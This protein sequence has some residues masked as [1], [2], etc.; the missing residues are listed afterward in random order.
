[1]ISR[2]LAGLLFASLI[3]ILPIDPCA[4]GVRTWDAG[5]DGVFW[6]HNC[7]WSGP[8]D[9]GVCFG[10]QPFD[11]DDAIIPFGN[12]VVRF[13]EG[14]ASVS[15][16]PG[17]RIDIDSALNAHNGVVNQAVI[18]IG[19]A[20]AQLNIGG[21]NP[22]NTLLQGGGEVI[23]ADSS[24]NPARVQ[25]AQFVSSVVTH[26]AG[27]TIR[28]EGWVVGKWINNG[29][30]R[31]EETSGDTSA[32]LS[33]FGT[34]TN[35]GVIRSS[36]TGAVHLDGALTMGAS[37]QFIADQTSIV[38]AGGSITGGTLQAINGAKFVHPSAVMTLS[39]VT[40]NG[41]LDVIVNNGGVTGAGTGI[42][43]NGTMTLDNQNIANGQ[44]HMEAGGTLNGS[45][46]V[47][48]NR[49]NDSTFISGNFTHG[50]N[51]TIRGSGRI[52]ATMV[53]N[54]SIFAEPRNGNLLRVPFSTISNN[55]L[56]QANGASTLRIEQNSII[57]Q[58]ASG[59][60]RALNGGTVELLFNPSIIGGRLQTE[61]TGLFVIP[62]GHRGYL[63]DVTNEGNFHADSGSNLRIEGTSLTNHGVI[64]INPAG[65]VGGTSLEF[66]SNVTIQ[67]TGT[68]VLNQA[69]DSA[70]IR[71]AATGNEIITQ[72]AGHTIRGR[73][74]I[75][76][77]FGNGMF[78]NHGRLEGESAAEPLF[79]YSN[80]SG[81]GTLKNVSIQSSLRK[82]HILG[83]VGT[84][85]VVH[86]EGLYNFS[87]RMS[88]LADLGGITPGTGYD[89]LNS[90]GPI[91]LNTTET[92]L[93][94]SIINGFVPAA[95]DQFTVM[96]T[97]DSL[98]GTFSA[99][100]L[101]ALI[102][103]FS[104]TWKPVQYTSNSV[105]LEVLSVAPFVADADFNNDGMFNCV[106]VDSLVVDIVGGQN[107]PLYDLTEDGLVN[108]SDLTRWL[109]DAGQVNLPSQNSYLEGDANLDG[110]VDGSD[111][112]VWNAHKFTNT[113]AWCSGDLN[114]SGS[115]DGSD[116]G[117]WNSNKFTSAL[118]AS[119]VVPEPSSLGLATLSCAVALAAMLNRHRRM[120]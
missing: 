78:V 119:A 80:L 117:I 21:F 102:P 79:I 19:A 101:P 50:A 115:V 107:G 41:D 48:L 59:R 22:S 49:A 60:I 89:Q 39:G 33:I 2:K 108:Q 61:G 94:A 16:A 113:P 99:I 116:F 14:V 85:A 70:E 3:A 28:G 110:V 42:T 96:T 118:D 67:G 32:T 9:Q 91:T 12:P 8:E 72:S 25:G 73:G 83:D 17:A 58:S 20:G 69:G 68:I 103:H 88:L 71:Y 26:A 51:H 63:T 105:I 87:G 112:G 90:I 43:N 97:T 65:V 62:S 35:N 64:T 53:N 36:A 52:S 106:D 76:N 104:L 15:L 13:L 38:L 47:I 10:F 6:D 75:D 56:L 84:T 55:G 54:G 18:D 31:A 114:A 92:R 66:G 100:S 86:A 81:D 74:Q 46:Q 95:G 7:N 11:G 24:S 45:G 34:M 5:G 120:T 98:T 23:L 82:N 27:N 109:S 30:I 37:G 1:M 40:I 4:G 77:T 111:F 57:T 44:L 29:L 93:E